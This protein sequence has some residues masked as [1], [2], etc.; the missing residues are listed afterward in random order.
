MRRGCECLGFSAGAGERKARKFK[1][2]DDCRI[3][4]F[5][6]RGLLLGFVELVAH[7]RCS[8]A[9]CKHVIADEITNQATLE[10]QRVLAANPNTRLNLTNIVF[11]SASIPV[12]NIV[13]SEE[14][15]DTSVN[16]YAKDIHQTLHSNSQNDATP[17]Y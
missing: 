17:V 11:S 2:V 4:R 16:Y 15:I 1:R 12:Q 14:V 13:Y 5:W 9:R 6:G 8:D 10:P 7:E 3:R